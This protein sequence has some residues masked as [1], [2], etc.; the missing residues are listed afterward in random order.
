MKKNI[1]ILVPGSFDEHDEREWMR[2]PEL[3]PEHAY[4]I[5][6]NK[7]MH[8]RTLYGEMGKVLHGDG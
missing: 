4:V 6:G 7:L 5:V 1:I 8:A 3:L 2:E